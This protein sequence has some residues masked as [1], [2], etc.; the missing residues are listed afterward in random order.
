MTSI[1]VKYLLEKEALVGPDNPEELMDDDESSNL[2]GFVTT[3]RI[4][5]KTQFNDLLKEACKFW[6]LK[7]DYEGQIDN[8]FHK[9]DF[10]L[11]G[12][13]AYR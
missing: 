6:V 10:E 4:S 2:R 7:G 3:F 9:G 8:Y 11:C 5:N 12:L 1:G 13:R